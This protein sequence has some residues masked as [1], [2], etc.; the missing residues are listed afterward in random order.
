MQK[1][2]AAAAASLLFA[3]C[4]GAT[5]VQES[6]SSL[7]ERD[8]TLSPSAAVQTEVASKIELATTSTPDRGHRVRAT[9]PIRKKVEPKAPPTPAPAPEPVAAPAPAP[10]SVAEA[11]VPASGHELAPGST[12]TVIPVS[13]GE[14]SAK[15]GGGGWSEVPAPKPGGV[16]IGAWPRGH[17]G[18]GG[19]EGPP[20][21]ILQ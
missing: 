13:T 15:G 8:L 7:P 21:S 20:V 11:P 16:A 1:I 2:I 9:T 18:S 5:R 10:V 4:G 6:A 12:V 19:R 17:C 14:S 3:A